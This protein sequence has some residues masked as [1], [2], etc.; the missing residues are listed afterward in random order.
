VL[1]A[2]LLCLI[3][4]TPETARALPGKPVQ[5]KCLDPCSGCAIL[6]TG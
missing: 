6:G 1:A 2:P 5:L 4:L 3:S